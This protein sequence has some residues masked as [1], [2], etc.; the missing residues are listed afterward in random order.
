MGKRTR[1][2]QISI[3]ETFDNHVVIEWNNKEYAVFHLDQEYI[4]M[5]DMPEYNC[6]IIHNVEKRAM[7]NIENIR[8]GVL[9]RRQEV[10]PAKYKDVD[11]WVQDIQ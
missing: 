2:S 3:K 7:L 9:I 5:F 10:N 6:E 11:D 1:E 8:T 4:R